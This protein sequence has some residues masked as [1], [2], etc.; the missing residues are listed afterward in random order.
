MHEVV[1]GIDFGSSE[2]GYAY[3]FNNKDDI[4]IGKFPGQI[5]DTKI[6]N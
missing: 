4:I 3:S 2:I 6:L 5:I 1:V